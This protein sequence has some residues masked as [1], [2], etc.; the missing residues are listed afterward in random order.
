MSIVHRFARCLV[1]GG[2]L[3]AGC[4][5]TPV[6]VERESTTSTSTTAPIAPPPTAGELRARVRG[7]GTDPSPDD[8]L[9]VGDSVMVLVTDDIATHLSSELH[10][11]AADCRR[12]DQ[13]IEGPCGGVPAGTVVADGVEALADQAASLAAEGIFPE[14]AVVILANNSSVSAADLDDAMAA[15]PGIDR[16]WWVTT[17][18]VGFGRQ[19]PNNRELEAL[20]RRDARAR[21]IDWFL[22]SEGQD[23]LADNVH[24][25]DAGQ[26]ALG[27]LI[28][29][30]VACDCI[31]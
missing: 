29:Y 28:A 10:I 23:W 11:D 20:A 2:L 12:I 26:R 9:L 22:A 31:P 14:V 19:D 8:V 21:V 4:S 15:I 7:I 3:V 6:A 16:V 24:P 13:A 30:H 17:R 18:I 1:A 27:R 25:N 5:A